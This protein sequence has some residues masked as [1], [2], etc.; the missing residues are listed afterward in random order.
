MVGELL[1]ADSDELLQG[2]DI[3]TDVLWNESTKADMVRFF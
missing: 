3:P 2:I 1:G